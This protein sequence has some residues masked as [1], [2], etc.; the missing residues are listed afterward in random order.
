MRNQ[1]DEPTHAA[2]ADCGD[3]SG[4]DE[5]EHI[6]AVIVALEQKGVIPGN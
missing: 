6:N 1:R 3:T 5:K 2:I 4:G